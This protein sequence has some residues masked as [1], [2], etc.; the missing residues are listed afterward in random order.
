MKKTCSI[1]AIAMLLMILAIMLMVA[2]GL[3]KIAL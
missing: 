1:W 3:I 2:A